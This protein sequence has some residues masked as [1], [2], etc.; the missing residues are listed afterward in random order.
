MRVS[1]VRT[2]FHKQRHERQPG[3]ISERHLDLAQ[4]STRW[5]TLNPFQSGFNNLAL[6]TSTNLASS[7]YIAFP[8]GCS[9]NALPTIMSGYFAFLNFSTKGPFAATKSLKALAV[10]PR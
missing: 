8:S 9:D 2:R 10:S 6:L 3:R 1:M 7:L 5:S 4:K